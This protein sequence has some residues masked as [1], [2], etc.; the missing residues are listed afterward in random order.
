MSNALVVKIAR[1]RHDGAEFYEGTA[2]IQGARPTKLTK[3]KTEE[4]AFSREADLR[5]AA[6][7]FAKRHSYG[8]VKFEG[9]T[10]AKV[11]K[12]AKTTTKKPCSKSKKSPCEVDTSNS[13]S[14]PSL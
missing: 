7:S 1:R 13:S 5:R 6:A 3:S 10:N 8:E 14:T 12:T 2:S 11:N 4:T 9:G